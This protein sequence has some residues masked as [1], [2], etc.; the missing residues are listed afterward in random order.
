MF[1]L[2]PSDIGILTLL[3]SF[4]LAFFI[5][6]RVWS[7]L[8]MLA[9]YAVV[10]VAP[11]LPWLNEKSPRAAGLYLI[12]VAVV[13]FLLRVRVFRLTK[14]SMMSPW[15]VS[16]PLAIIAGG[17]LFSRFLSFLPPTTVEHLSDST[18]SLFLLPVARILWNVLPLVSIV[19]VRSRQPGPVSL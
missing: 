16:I 17:F 5:F 9:G 15:V 12:T 8:G 6:G 4:I 3:G 1:G 11:T 19:A 2:S 18:R 14:S 7:V 13:T 10:V